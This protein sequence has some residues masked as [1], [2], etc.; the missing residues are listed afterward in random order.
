MPSSSIL[1]FRGNIVDVDRL[2]ESHGQLHDGSP[3]KKGLGHITRSG[4]VMLCAAWELYLE[5][6]CVE[7]ANYFCDK[8]QSPDQLPRRVQK[9]LA[10]VAR[11]SKHEL[12]PLEFAG[13]G[14]KQVLVTHV[15]ELCGAINTPKAGPIDELYL[16]AIGL[17]R[18]SDHWSCGKDTINDFVGVRGDI[19]HRGRDADYIKIGEL[20]S[21]RTLI[22]AT[23]VE[24]DNAVSELLVS[25]TPGNYKP[26]RVTT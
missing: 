16:R 23:A 2:I 9:E 6:L 3:G 18:L 1:A 19:A 14:W 24:C 26:W 21:Y 13:D 15:R 10:K 7:A 5:S 12:K 25:A 11:E 17:E 22:D 4:V 20:Q 8:C